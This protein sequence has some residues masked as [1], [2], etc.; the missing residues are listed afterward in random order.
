[1]TLSMVFGQS[2]PWWGYYTWS[3]FDRDCCLGGTQLAAFRLNQ[4]LQGGNMGFWLSDVPSSA[5]PWSSKYFATVRGGH[6]SIA[7]RVTGASRERG[8][9]PFALLV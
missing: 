4:R 5:C 2:P 1:M 3:D 9:R 6:N 7:A 8:V